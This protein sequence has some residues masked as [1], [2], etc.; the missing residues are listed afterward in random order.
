MKKTVLLIILLMIFCLTACYADT[1]IFQRQIDE[2][3]GK[4]SQQ[5]DRIAEIEDE[6]A[7]LADRIA[8]LEE[9][10]TSLSDKITELEKQNNNLSDKITE[11]E[12]ELQYLNIVEI[13]TDDMIGFPISSWSSGSSTWLG[14]PIE[15]KHPN[16]KAVFECTADTGHFYIKPP[17]VVPVEFVLKAIVSAGEQVQWNNWGDDP[18]SLWSERV[19][20]DIILKIDGNFAGYAVVEID[21][22]IDAPGLG[23]YNAKLLKSAFFP[24]I[25]GKYQSITEEQVKTL[26]KK[27]KDN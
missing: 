25:D 1:S 16:E 23:S 12:E 19:L 7:G 6:N 27:V 17:S 13:E 20:V 5:A 21:K 9:Q 11:M 2:L 3:K 4:E 24:Q 14:Y 22:M 15:L 26:I 18:P 8:E 10:N